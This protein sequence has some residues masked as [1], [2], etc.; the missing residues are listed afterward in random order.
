VAFLTLATFATIAAGCSGPP[1]RLTPPRAPSPSATATPLVSP[2]GTPTPTP[3]PTP[4]PTPTPTT[5]PTPV[6]TQT[7]DPSGFTITGSPAPTYAKLDTKM[8]T[9]M[10]Q[11]GI[12]AGQLAIGKA[13]TIVFSHGYTN[14]TDP[15]YYVTQP[16]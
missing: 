5:T 4:S 10:Q 7:P 13:G 8:Q 2:T 6:A 12:R 1:V 11:F 16:D 15:T 3:S 9:F 14:T